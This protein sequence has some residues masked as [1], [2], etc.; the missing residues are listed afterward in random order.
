MKLDVL[1]SCIIPSVCY[2]GELFGMN[3]SLVSKLES[4][5]GKAVKMLVKGWG[6]SAVSVLQYEMGLSSVYEATSAM[7][8]RAFKKFPTLSTLIAD[9]CASPVRG[10]WFAQTRSWIRRLMGEE[11]VGATANVMKGVKSGMREEKLAMWAGSESSS[12]PKGAVMYARHEFNL[13][14]SYVSVFL[15]FCSTNPVLYKFDSGLCSLIAM[16]CGAF[17]SAYRLAKAKLISARYLTYCPCCERR[18]RES[19]FHIL[20]SCKAWKDDRASALIDRK[21]TAVRKLLFDQ[22]SSVALLLGGAAGDELCERFSVED[23]WFKGEGDT[24]PF[25]LCLVEFLTQIHSRRVS[26]IWQHAT[27]ARRQSP[28]G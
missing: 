11:W 2:G 6:Y 18:V 21:V 10:A 25:F 7:R 9:V 20:F 12:M 19:V 4:V 26:A 14:R 1:R 15:K 22:E 17:W 5:W 27:T 13:S 28:H 3:K 24:P 16:R 8:V 23:S